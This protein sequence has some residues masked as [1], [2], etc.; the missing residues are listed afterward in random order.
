MAF[1]AVEGEGTSE[2][3]VGVC[4]YVALPDGKTCEYA[5]VV[6]DD[7]QARGLG[8]RMMSRLMEVAASRGLETMFGYV[9]SDNSG[10]LQLCESLG[11]AIE[12]EPDDPH[13]RRVT[14][15]L[16]QAQISRSPSP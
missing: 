13:T 8:R 11:F 1:I 4:R 2:R 14:L 6:S 5:I 9:A 12:P 15:D 7:F 3:E 10:M 16:C